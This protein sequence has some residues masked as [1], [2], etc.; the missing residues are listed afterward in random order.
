[1]ENWDKNTKKY[2]KKC[3]DNWHIKNEWSRKVAFN[4]AYKETVKY[5]KK[6]HTWDKND[7]K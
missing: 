6:R 2:F 7:K 1:M 5:L 4:E 3:F